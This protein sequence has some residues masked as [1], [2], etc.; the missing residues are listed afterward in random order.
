MNWI[1][2][3]G[4]HG[5]WGYIHPHFLNIWASLFVQICIE[6]V[7]VGWGNCIGDSTVQKV[8]NSRPSRQQEIASPPIPNSFFLWGKVGPPDSP[9]N[10]CVWHSWKASSTMYFQTPG[11]S[12]NYTQHLV[13]VERLLDL[14]P[15]MLSWATSVPYRSVNR[16]LVGYLYLFVSEN[17]WQCE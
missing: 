11:S 12:L 5:V 7:R 15:W 14:G 8:S 13:T 6:T 2:P 3:L 17:K 4:S 10:S 16:H 9:Q 1:I